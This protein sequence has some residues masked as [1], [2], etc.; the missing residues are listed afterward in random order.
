MEPGAF[1]SSP[2]RLILLPLAQPKPTS[3]ANTTAID[4]FNN[5]RMFF[6]FAESPPL[7][8]VF[9]PCGHSY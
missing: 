6:P 5:S 7:F 3:T 8:F 4:I 2:A 9:R 1:S